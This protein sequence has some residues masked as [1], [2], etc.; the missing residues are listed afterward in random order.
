[1]ATRNVA[2]SLFPVSVELRLLGRA[3]QRWNIRQDALISPDE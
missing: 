1:L 3:A 2:D